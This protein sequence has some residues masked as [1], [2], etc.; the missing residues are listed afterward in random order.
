M[1]DGPEVDGRRR[2]EIESD[3]RGMVPYYVDGWEPDEGDVGTGL[4]RLFSELTE[5]VT[6]RLDRVPEKH[7][8]AF[9]ETLG[10]GR[11]PPQ[12]ARVPLVVD[13]A[14]GAGET[15][16]VRSGT[17]ATAEG[18]DGS[19][20]LFEI[21][22][23]ETFDATPARIRAVYGVLPDE[24]AIYA[25]HDAVG[26]AEESVLFDASAPDDRQRH[27][28]Y[29]GDAA[30]FAAGSGTSLTLAFETDADPELLAE[31]LAW[32]FHGEATVGG[33]SVETWHDLTVTRT[34]S[35]G[36]AVQLTFDPDGTLTET[37]V[38]GVESAWIRG[39]VPA[40]V[41]ASE[42]AALFDVA[43][44]TA[45]T[46]DQPVTAGVRARGLVPD[47]LLHNDVPQPQGA[48]T[49]LI[50]PFG[51]RPRVQDTFYLASTDALTKSAAWVVV[52]FR[53]PD[54]ERP[55]STED[56]P[57]L[58]W[59]Y[60]DGDAWARLAPV[61]DF[62]RSLQ[63][64][65]VVAFVPPTDL[66][67]TT[68]AGREGHWIR[69]RLVDGDYG[70]M[71]VAV[72][73]WTA[74]GDPKEFE[75]T[76]DY[77][78]PTFESVGLDVYDGGAN[79]LDHVLTENNLAFG[80]DLAAAERGGY[81]PFEPLPV[82]E[83][84]LFVGVDAALT[85][86][87]ITLL[88]DLADAAYPR[89][90]HPQ[91]RYEYYDAGADRWVRPDVVDGTE[92]LTERG[93]VRFGFP[94]ATSSCT[95]FGRELHWL[96]ARVTGDQFGVEPDESDGD[97]RGGDTGTGGPIR[98]SACGRFVE[99]TPPA[100]EPAATPPEVGGLY[101]NAVWARNR[102]TVAADVVGSSDGSIE[103]SFPVAN[104]PVV[105]PTLWVDELAVLSEGA[106]RALTERWP[107]RTDRE[108]N[109]A[110]EPTAFWVE[111]ERVSDRLDSGPE[112]RHYT[113]D[114]VVGTVSFGDG[115]RGKIPP[116]GT[117][118]VRMTY[119]TGGGAAGNVPAGAVTGFQQSLA[120]VERVTNPIAA[121]GGAAAEAT[122]AVTDR[123][124][125]ELRDRNRA[126]ASVDYERLSLDGSRQLARARCLP[127]MDRAGDYAP[128]WVTVL[129]VPE[130]AAAKPVPAATLRQEVERGLTERAPAAL[131]A[132]DRLVVRGPSYVL[133]SVETRLVAAGGSIAELE[134][135]ARDAL[136][137]YLHPLTGGPTGD[138]WP[139]GELPC[140]S[141]VFALL[142]GVERVDH[143]DELRVTFET[144][145]STV[146]VE[147]GEAEPETSP[148][149]LVYSGAHDVSARFAGPGGGRGR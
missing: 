78:P 116:R 61:Y 108:T 93:I 42:R 27:A 64:G 111:W 126:V 135:R 124:A 18:A 118:N 20:Q 147:E 123:A 24:D 54:V 136:Q 128:G 2:A 73:D 107:D 12:Q 13:V 38:G 22:S 68:V 5:E 32:E 7:R 125:K 72:T 90:F 47:E 45:G 65:G 74:D 46:T 132:A 59:E 149:A 14:P 97:E 115:T 33:E 49:G 58:S 21:P 28:L 63:D 109:G 15:V 11:L 76:P 134:A 35:V 96:R 110:G 40:D 23:G 146:T 79:R 31:G 144:E 82:D 95:L 43:F 55:D 66:S 114:P 50:R 51:T 48:G 117:D 100:G 70:R 121:A 1:P 67:K 143:V 84:T 119:T 37:E 83:Q 94:E 17:Q 34:Q 101:L 142:E 85:D 140:L 80:D 138:G 86:G 104:R 36:G 69:A 103:Q 88:F 16:T 19:E 81:R 133:A 131:V 77:R 98:E 8:V 148:D 71:D 87:P 3:V 52:H 29:L 75:P 130:S 129:V 112:D 139:F 105:E 102:R 89:E 137:S 99:T 30:Q 26:G 122:E 145:R 4:V 41:D 53:E 141:D 127:A 56:P 113:L 9:Y 62:T 25:H 60:Y 6:A 92:G 120:F 91:V 106:R 57:V 10:F 44:G 39:R